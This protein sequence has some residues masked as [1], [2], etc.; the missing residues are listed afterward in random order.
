MNASSFIQLQLSVNLPED[1]KEFLDKTGYLCFG[2]ISQEIY[3]Y[4]QEFDIEKLPCVIAA[5]KNSEEDYSLN[6]REIVLSHTGYEDHI[7]ILDTQ[8]SYVFEV[9][10]DGH[11]EKLAD[12]F[13]DWLS[14]M[15]ARNE[16][17]NQG[18]NHEN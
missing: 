18:I 5:T 11:K 15:L 2:N 16:N 4:K 1:Y 12:S 10:L 9:S 3:G 7:V 6:P 17:N 14:V 13:S 8:T